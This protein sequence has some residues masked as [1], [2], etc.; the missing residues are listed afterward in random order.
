[1]LLGALL[2]LAVRLAAES[3]LKEPQQMSLAELNLSLFP[4]AA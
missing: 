3:V 2:H 4:H 1:M